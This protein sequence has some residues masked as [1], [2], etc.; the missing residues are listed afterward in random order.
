MNM[1][2]YIERDHVLYLI[3]ENK[4]S[5]MN[6]DILENG[7]RELPPA[8]VV[9]VMCGRWEQMQRCPDAYGTTIATCPICNKRQR[10]GDYVEFC[11]ACGA[12]MEGDCK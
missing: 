1:I 6:W 12:R 11:P 9:E 4:T 7:V 3:D 10:L 5:E 8:D 2:E